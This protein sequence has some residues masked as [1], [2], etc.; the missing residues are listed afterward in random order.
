MTFNLIITCAKKQFFQAENK[1]V[2]VVDFDIT[3]QAE[4]L[5]D[6]AEIVASRSLAFTLEAPATE[7]K[8]ELF[9]YLE[10]YTSEAQSAITNKLQDEAQKNANITIEELS[11]LKI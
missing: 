8:A 1:E 3:K 2:L 5:E 10:N 9:K 11:G 7:V 4:G 6:E